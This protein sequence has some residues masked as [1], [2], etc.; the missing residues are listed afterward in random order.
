MTLF[1]LQLYAALVVLLSPEEDVV[2]RIAAMSTLREVMDDFTFRPAAV[3][4]FLADLMPLLFNL[5]ATVDE[6]D[7]KMKVLSTLTLSIERVGNSH[8]QE[9]SNTLYE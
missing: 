9:Y 3:I 5:L 4:P 8:M 2:V 7:S 1:T 6:C